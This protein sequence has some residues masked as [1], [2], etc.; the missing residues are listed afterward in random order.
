MKSSLLGTAS[1]GL[2]CTAAHAQPVLSRLLP[3]SNSW[4]QHNQSGAHAISTSGLYVAGW[5]GANWS[6]RLARWTIVSASVGPATDLGV[7]NGGDSAIAFAIDPS[8][9]TLVGSAQASSNGA[10]HAFK[11]S[12]DNNF[13]DL[14][15][16]STSES[17]AT[18]ISPNGVHVVGWDR[19][20]TYKRAVRWGGAASISV[21]TLPGHIESSP[22]A[23]DWTGNVVIG[24]S[25]ATTANSMLAFRWTPTDG[26]TSMGLAPNATTSAATAMS[27]NAN[28]IAGTLGIA[29]GAK[30]A[31]W[32]AATGW[33][34]L[35]G[36]PDCE[37]CN[38][39]SI[40]SNGLVIVGD[41]TP[42]GATSRSFVWTQALGAVDLDTLL[43]SLGTIP[44]WSLSQCTDISDDGTK[45]I[46]NTIT[47]TH[48]VGW[49]AQ[50]LPP[51]WTIC[52][53]DLD[54]GTGTGRRDLAV[55]VDDLLFFLAKYEAGAQEADLDDD[56]DP[57]FPTR[58]EAVTIAD[59]L[60]FL[61]RFESGC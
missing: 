25:R 26:M 6:S 41:Y 4:Y 10:N 38:A 12:A 8:G 61:S 60:Y 5:S 33:E 35:S 29:Q 2:L 52:P 47:G 42:V 14:A 24:W 20:G 37:S 36:L 15:A 57:T 56:G 43:R 16:G 9:S 22:T 23:V 58:D 7:M 28:V 1:L 19:T 3:I 55:N 31:R 54:N 27:H 21:G 30:C 59:L 49:I 53:I 18:A 44:T 13:I 40:T 46:G 34:V 48:S 17:S 50:R 39:R 45:A 11:W 32:T 51:L